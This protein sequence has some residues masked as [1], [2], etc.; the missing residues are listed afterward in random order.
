MLY[1]YFVKGNLKQKSIEEKENNFKNCFHFLL[2]M[3][4]IV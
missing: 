3:L 4:A 1:K 2:L